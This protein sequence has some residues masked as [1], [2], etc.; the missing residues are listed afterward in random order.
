M[1]GLIEPSPL[2]QE[3]RPETNVK[4][5]VIG[6]IAVVAVVGVIALLTRA[7]PKRLVEPHPYAANLKLSDLKMS[8]AENFVGASVTYIDGTVTN[9]GD[10][11]VTHAVVHVNFKN[12]L[13]QI[14]Q[15]EDVPLHVLQTSG[16]YPD[17]VDLSASPLAPG[18]SKPF[19]LTFEHVSTDWNQAYPE[20]EVTDVSLK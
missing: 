20:L 15:A 7:A 6:V 2:R 18:Q 16:P 11:T 13:D 1:G 14:A 9:A 8:A 5:I 10:K 19:R 3:E 4:A 12:S 17:T